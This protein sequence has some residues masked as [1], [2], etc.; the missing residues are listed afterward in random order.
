MLQTKAIEPFTLELL[1]ELMQK[2]YLEKFNLVGE[3]SLALQLGHRLSVDLD[4]FTTTDFNSDEILP[5]ILA[6]FSEVELIHKSPKTLILLINTIKVDLIKFS[7]PLFHPLIIDQNIRLQNI[8]DI[9]PT[10]LDAI[11]GRGKKKDFYDL[12]YLLHSDSLQEMFE[13]YKKMFPHS[14][15]FHVIKSITYFDDADVDPDPIVFDPNITRHFVKQE[16]IKHTK[17]LL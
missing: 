3:T 7:Y 5:R 10:K 1:S 14:T 4:L 17:K 11:A 13:L 12:F 16:I 8:K 2:L 15:I 9:I 6:D